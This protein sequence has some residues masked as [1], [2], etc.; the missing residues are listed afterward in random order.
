MTNPTRPFL[1]RLE[2]ARRAR[3]EWQAAN[4]ELSAAWDAAIDEDAFRKEAALKAKEAQRR[5]ESVL[6]LCGDAGMPLRAL[7]AISELR[8]TQATEV[9]ASGAKG[10]VLLAGPPGTGKSVAAVAL[11][12]VAMTSAYGTNPERVKESPQ[13]VAIF[14][15]AVTLARASAY[16]AE[17]NATIRDLASTRLL[18]LDDLGAEFASSVWDMLLFEILD[19][20]HGNMLPTILTSNLGAPEF[21]KRYGT[22]LLERIKEGGRAVFLNGESMRGA[23]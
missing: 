20:R 18:I 1:A 19:T 4:P 23:P 10:M 9:L 7:K 6:D 3:D 15:R 16:G 11:A 2:E 14:A 21:V 8:S 12:Y 5:R 13:R 17:A 22:R